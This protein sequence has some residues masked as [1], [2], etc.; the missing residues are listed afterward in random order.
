MKTTVLNVMDE[1]CPI[2][3]VKAARALQE[4]QAPGILEVLVSSEN[5]ATNLFHMARGH[6]LPVLIEK[7]EEGKYSVRIEVAQPVGEVNAEETAIHCDVSGGDSLVVAV[8]DDQMGGGDPELG[9][10][11]MKSFLFAVSQLPQLPKTILFYNAG[12]RLTAE[13][14]EVLEDL[15]KMEEQ[16]VQILTCGTCLNFY[17]LTEKLAVGQVTNMYTIVE[18]L[19][20][21]SRVLRP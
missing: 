14:S 18:T 3:V 16:G 12:A 13:G 6:K 20:A 19:A 5:A 2:P 7:K 17:H 11:L 9:H 10:I 21:A 1:K 15:K 4:M 8:S